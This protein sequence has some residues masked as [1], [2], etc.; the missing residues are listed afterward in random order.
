MF[1]LCP[2]LAYL[3]NV[4]RQVML[5]IALGDRYVEPTE[6]IHIKT[7]LWAKS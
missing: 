5:W 3:N 4:N 6:N 1:Y 7:G 2:T